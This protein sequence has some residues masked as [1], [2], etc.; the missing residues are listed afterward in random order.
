LTAGLLLDRYRGLPGDGHAFTPPAEAFTPEQAAAIEALLAR[1]RKW[2]PRLLGLAAEP[3]LGVVP[4]GPDVQLTALM[5]GA[6]R[7]VLVSNPSMDQYA[8]G[9]V[10]LPGSIGGMPAHRAV[11]V[12]PTSGRVA[13]RVSDARGGRIALSVTLRPGDA[14][15]FEMF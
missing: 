11:E 5:R 9:Q 12:P 4:G 15:L 7:Y 1:A 14:A 8:R 2:G 6:Q 13:G 10:V 3:I